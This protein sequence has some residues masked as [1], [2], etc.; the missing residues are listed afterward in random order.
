MDDEETASFHGSRILTPGGPA[1]SDER[2]STQT[3]VS[4]SCVVSCR[5]FGVVDR[6]CFL[7]TRELGV[8]FLLHLPFCLL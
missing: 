7:A 3:C 6:L 2:I 1:S 8:M 4:I 5:H